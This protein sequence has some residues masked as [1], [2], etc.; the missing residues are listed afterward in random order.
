MG[1]GDLLYHETYKD[2]ACGADS[3]KEQ[4]PLPSQNLGSVAVLD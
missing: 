3:S 4:S 1:P 2:L